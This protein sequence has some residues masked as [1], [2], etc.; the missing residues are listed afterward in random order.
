MSNVMQSSL[1]DITSDVVARPRESVWPTLSMDKALSIIEQCTVDTFAKYVPITAVR[2]GHVLAECVVAL[3]DVPEMRTSM[4]DGYAVIASEGPGNREVVGSSSAGTPF[5]G[6]LERG[7]CVRISTGGT[8]PPGSDAVVM[9]ER[10]RLV[11]HDNVEELIINIE[12]EIQPGQ[13]IRMP[14]SDIRAG[15]IMLDK[16]HVLGSAEIGIL[17]GSGRKSVLIYR[18]PKVCVMSTGNELVECNADVVPLGHIRDT[19]R[20][21]LLSLFNSSGFK[22]I[23]A[24][25]AAD[26]RVCLVDA[27]R[28]AFR[29]AN[30][31]ITSGGV[32][33]GEKD[34]VKDVLQKEFGFQIHFGRV[35]MKPGLP[36]MFASGEVDGVKKLVVGLPV[37]LLRKMA[38]HIR[39]RQNEI[40]VKITEMI[41]LDVRPEYRRAWLQYGEMQ[42]LAITTGNQISSRLGINRRISNEFHSGDRSFSNGSG[43]RLT[44]VSDIS[45]LGH[46]RRRIEMN[47]EDA[48]TFP[49]KRQRIDDCEDDADY[50]SRPKKTLQSTV[51]MPSIETKSREEKIEELNKTEKKE[52][53]TRSVTSSFH[54]FY[55]IK[56]HKLVIS[57]LNL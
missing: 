34:L 51:V 31:L 26:S 16:G 4:K 55:F 13:D 36:S 39:F 46:N 6:H 2:V 47:R 25:I 17:A 20:P 12:G 32:S 48:R 38:G 37:P 41:N 28:V 40:K 30:V 56:R 42:P 43:R 9:V 50:D 21:Q 18:K 15:D 19:N 45:P 52:I 54:L 24:G 53:V 14:G 5:L 44:I 10:T 22:A 33:M 35:W 57:L 1:D 49:T 8:V 7:Q 29:F 23:D 11:T 3:S 27:M